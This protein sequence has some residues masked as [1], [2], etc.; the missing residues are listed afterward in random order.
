MGAPTARKYHRY[1]AFYVH[2]AGLG[3]IE[4]SRYLYIVVGLEP[5]R[6]ISENGRAAQ[7][8]VFLVY[9]VGC[10]CRIFRAEA[11]DRNIQRSVVCNGRERGVKGSA[12]DD[13]R[14][15]FFIVKC[16]IA[17]GAYNSYAYRSLLIIKT[18]IAAG[19]LAVGY[20]QSAAVIIPYAEISFAGRIAPAY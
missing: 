6:C 5:D 16:V 8:H 12:I 10:R 9:H 17:F 20:I 14:A 19:N 18:I 13:R 3:H 7:V 15:F 2:Q 1:R 11:A 4:L